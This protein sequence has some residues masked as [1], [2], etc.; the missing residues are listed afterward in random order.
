MSQYCLGRRDLPRYT[1]VL[2]QQ[3]W[4]SALHLLRAYPARPYRWG[5][6]SE[7]L[8]TAAAL[9]DN[10]RHCYPILACAVQAC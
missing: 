8:T 5:G 3:G 1:H 10:D 2:E 4:P 7:T 9:A 6:L